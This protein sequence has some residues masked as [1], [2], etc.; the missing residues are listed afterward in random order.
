MSLII[1]RAR[2]V[3]D[4]PFHISQ[5]S[6]EYFSYS[7]QPNMPAKAL[8]SLHLHSKQLFHQKNQLARN[9]KILALSLTSAIPNQ[10]QCLFSPMQINHGTDKLGGSCWFYPEWPSICWVVFDVQVLWCQPRVYWY[11]PG[12]RSWAHSIY[13][14]CKAGKGCQMSI[15]QSPNK[16]GACLQYVSPSITRPAGIPCLIWLASI[17]FNFCTEI[18]SLSWTNPGLPSG[19]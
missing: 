3:Q 9:Y 4:I 18:W 10:T 11:F 7:Q 2:N 16:R 17:A 19:Q 13:N 14:F 15:Q 12:V 5:V 1:F 8:H 6:T